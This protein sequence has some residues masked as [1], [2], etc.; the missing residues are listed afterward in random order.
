MLLEVKCIS[1]GSP[2]Y[3]IYDENDREDVFI[4]K[5]PECPDFNCYVEV[6]AMFNKYWDKSVSIKKGLTGE[7]T[8]ENEEGKW[9]EVYKNG[10]V[11]KTEKSE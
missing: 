6:G 7:L 11:I 8:F 4:C 3:L 1:C 2:D 9:H 5:N 10:R